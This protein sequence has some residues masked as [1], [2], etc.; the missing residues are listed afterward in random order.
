MCMGNYRAAGNLLL[1]ALHLLDGSQCKFSTGVS[2]GCEGQ[3]LQIQP[4]M[5]HW[6]EAESSF[7]YL[8]HWAFTIARVS[9]GD[10]SSL[11]LSDTRIT[12]ILL[13]NTGLCCQAMGMAETTEHAFFNEAFKLYTMA[14][15]LLDFGDTNDRLLHL[16]VLNNRGF[17]MACFYEY[18]AAQEC[19]GSLKYLLETTKTS[20]WA[21]REHVLQIHMNVTLLYGE[22]THA[23]AA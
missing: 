14:L 13:Y 16:A 15:L 18:G 1:V 9:D 19:L 17:I 7:F 5:I 6:R 3:D 11:F 23:G 2:I 21:I 22:H 20:E 10:S 12:A 8:Y 4:V